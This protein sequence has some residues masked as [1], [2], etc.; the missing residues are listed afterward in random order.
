MSRFRKGQKVWYISSKNWDLEEKIAQGKFIKY[1]EYNNSYEPCAKI[2]PITEGSY[3]CEVLQDWIFKT[4]EEAI[5]KIKEILKTEIREK[6]K[7]I[8]NLRARLKK[9]IFDLS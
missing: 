7:E 8:K 5:S 6:Q 9:E 4:K 3:D 1:S 2:K